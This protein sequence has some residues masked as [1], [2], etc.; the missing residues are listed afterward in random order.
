MDDGGYIYIA[1]H[2]D[3]MVTTMRHIKEAKRKVHLYY[4]RGYLCF[5]LWAKPIAKPLEPFANY[6]CNLV[7]S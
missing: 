7:Q 2:F 3:V 5:T 1:V 4:D 6:L